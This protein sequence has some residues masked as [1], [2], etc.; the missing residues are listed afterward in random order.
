MT[1]PSL[2][3][4][5]IGVGFGMGEHHL[6]QMV[7]RGVAQHRLDLRHC[8]PP[9]VGI[10]GR[11]SRPSERRGRRGSST[12]PVHDRRPT[13]CRSP[14]TRC[15]LTDRVAVVTGAAQGIGEAIA[16]TLARFGAHVAVCDKLPDGLAA[17]VSRPRGD[18]RPRGERGDGR[19]RRRR[20][21]ALPRAGRRRVR[22]GRR[23][24][25]QRRRRVLRPVHG[26]CRPR[27][28]RRW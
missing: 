7:E 19:P 27:A 15:S 25:Q 14:R 8:R 6:D 26:R 4:A 28:G 13:I 12:M 16:L 24:G 17:T 9:F 23:A 20:G 1:S 11:Q 10:H 5:A 3:A 18:R 21:R 2:V 22:P